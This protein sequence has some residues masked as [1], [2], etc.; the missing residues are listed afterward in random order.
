MS[1]RPLFRPTWLQAAVLAGVAVI[2]I[3]YAAMLRYMSIETSAVALACDAGSTYWMCP[4]R[5]IAL[6]FSQSSA[7]G[8]IAL[9]AALLNLVRPTFVLA[10]IVLLA[11]GF[12][13]V[14]YN[15]AT[16][17]VAVALLVLSRA[18]PVPEPE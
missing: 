13:L 6:A 14:L 2:A 7:L 18:R 17:A 3:G 9:A 16:S 12:G 5:K 11:A 10:C 15:T 1:T 8:A 4:S